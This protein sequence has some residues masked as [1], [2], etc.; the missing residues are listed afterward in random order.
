MLTSRVQTPRFETVF[1]PDL[2]LMSL[3]IWKLENDRNI[4]E[5]NLWI[6]T[7]LCL[8][9]PCLTAHREHDISYIA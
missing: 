4:S 8:T 3:G 7:A 6:D 5:T 1:S 9:T 2:G